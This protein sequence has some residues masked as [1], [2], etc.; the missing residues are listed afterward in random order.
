MEMQKENKVMEVCLL[1]GKLLLESGAETYRVEDTMMRVAKAFGV[2]ACECF[3]IPTGIIMTVGHDDTHTKLVRVSER[4]TDLLKVT[5]V[6]RISRA[7]SEGALS[8]EGAQKALEETSKAGFAFS[9]PVQ[10]CGAALSSS[11]FVIMFQGDW[12]DFLA[13]LFAGA[14]GY[15]GYLFFA[16]LVSVK[17]I[18]EFLASA[19]IGFSS[20]LLLQIGIG[21]EIDKIIIGSVMPLVPGLLITNAVRDLIAGHLVSGLSKG[22]EAFLT[23]SAIGAGIAI[24]LTLV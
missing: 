23:S 6:N 14:L 19:I 7:I 10:I 8:L 2:K 12:W 18:S 5:R 17:F 1:A 11:C 15:A 22:V 9:I 3:V 20:Y 16:W 21:S 13:A 24:V 4:T